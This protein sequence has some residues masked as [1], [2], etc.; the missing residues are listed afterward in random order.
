MKNLENNPEQTL[1][2]KKFSELNLSPQIQKD[3]E[4][5]KF[6]TMMPV[7]ELAI[8]ILLEGRDL[9]AQAKTGTGKT[10]AF[11]IPLMEKVDPANRN[12]QALVMAPTREL[13][14]QVAGEMR[15]IGYGK[16]VRTTSVY[17][18]KSIDQQAKQLSAGSPIVVGTP[19]RIMDM[20]ERR[21]LRL[22]NVKILVLDEADRMLDMGFI[23]DI[24][25]IIAHIPKDRQTMLFSATIPDRI[26]QLA[27]TIMKHP[28]HVSV[29]P[30]ELTVNEIEQ[31]YYETPQNVK[32]DAFMSVVQT[33][34]PESAIIFTNTKRW[35]DT[36][37]SMMQRRGMATEAIHGDLSQNQRDRVIEGFKRKRFTF[38]VATDV[39]ARGLDIDDVTHVFNYDIPREKENYVHR[40]GRTGRAGKS[41]KAISFISPNEIHDLWAM[42]HACRTK[43][44]EAKLTITL[45]AS[46]HS[47][48]KLSPYEDSSPRQRSSRGPPRRSNSNSR[49]NR[50][51][52]NRRY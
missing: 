27:H 44:T 16:R 3:L 43:I 26:G 25:K 23:D 15:K 41:G 40:I 17:G 31:F 33:E 1:E 52:S 22:D 30:E 2:N 38:M 47:R 9:I 8:P 32:F 4:H 24:R 21:L 45:E 10:L 6:V 50:G 19:G 35:A 12:V 42:E 18:G 39:A 49:D 48:P 11:G 36:L 5:N 20:I 28:E 46:T 7:Q 29:S 13:A 51:R 37:T 34:R 14:E